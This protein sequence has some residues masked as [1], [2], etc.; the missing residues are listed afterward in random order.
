MTNT[1]TTIQPLP[2]LNP[3]FGPPYQS[4]LPSHENLPIPWQPVPA[5]EPLQPI[6]TLSGVAP[7]PPTIQPTGNSFSN[8]SVDVA[9]PAHFIP[10]IPRHLGERAWEQVVRDWEEIDPG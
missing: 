10:E 8:S 3:C 1:T 6:I 2:S 9:E 5:S 4:T 7:S